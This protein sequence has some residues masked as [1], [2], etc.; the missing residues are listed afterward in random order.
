LILT[1]NNDLISP[2]L[3][4]SR[5]LNEELLTAMNAYALEIKSSPSQ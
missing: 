4:T 1:Y 2:T 5:A 3:P